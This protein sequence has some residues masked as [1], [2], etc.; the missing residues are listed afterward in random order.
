MR[1]YPPLRIGYRPIGDG[2]DAVRAVVS[3]GDGQVLAI[4]WQQDGRTYFGP[5]LPHAG[6]GEL[7]LTVGGGVSI[8]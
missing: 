8:E 7:S 5:V 6:N 1:V 3:G 2:T 4:R